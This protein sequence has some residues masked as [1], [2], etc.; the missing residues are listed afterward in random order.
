MFDF[1]VMNYC[2]YEQMPPVVFYEKLNVKRDVN[3]TITFTCQR[4]KVENNFPVSFSCQ[5]FK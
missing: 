1:S 3:L 2:N 4:A 5:N